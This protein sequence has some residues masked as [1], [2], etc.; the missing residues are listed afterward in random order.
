VPPQPIL[1]LDSL[2]IRSAS[3]VCVINHTEAQYFPIM[4]KES[5][6]G[7]LIYQPVVVFFFNQTE[8]FTLTREINSCATRRK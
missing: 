3:Y 7:F 4:L 8:S 5:P 6:N 1:W 2:V